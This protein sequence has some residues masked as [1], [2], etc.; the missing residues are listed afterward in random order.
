MFHI[1]LYLK[2]MFPLGD[3]VSL[4]LHRDYTAHYLHG[5]QL[6]DQKFF[7]FLELSHTVF[8]DK[9]MV[10]HLKIIL[11]ANLKTLIFIETWSICF[12]RNQ[13]MKFRIF[14]LKKYSSFVL[15][16]PDYCVNSQLFLSYFYLCLM[17][18]FVSFIHL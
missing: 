11:L 1:F 9:N 16:S 6:V 12:I 4:Y 17:M 14:C 7:L 18:V 15:Y 13:E 8:A 2:K 10:L 5:K 3:L